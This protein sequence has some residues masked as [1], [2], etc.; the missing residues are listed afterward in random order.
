MIMTL[1]QGLAI[2]EIS[3]KN[4]GHTDVA[5]VAV[6]ET[7]AVAVITTQVFER[8]RAICGQGSTDKIFYGIRVTEEAMY[9]SDAFLSHMP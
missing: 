8:M 6:A 4:K 2:Y 7:L 5:V 1:A 9:L 3:I